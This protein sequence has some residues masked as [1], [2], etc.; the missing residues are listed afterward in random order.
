[1]STRSS[2]SSRY[3]HSTP[4]TGCCRGVALTPTGCC[5]LDR[6]LGLVP[7]SHRHLE[8]PQP[9]H[10]RPHAVRHSPRRGLLLRDTDVHN[11][12]ALSDLELAYRPAHLP[13]RQTTQ[14]MERLPNRRPISHPDNNCMGVVARC[15]EWHR[16]I[17]WLDSCL[18]WAVPPAVVVRPSLQTPNNTLTKAQ[19]S[20]IPVYPR[21][22]PEQHTP[23]H[24]SSHSLPL[25]RRYPGFAQRN[26]GHCDRD[27][28]QHTFVGRLGH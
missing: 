24:C 28:V 5:Y 6:P 16:R 2:S 26:M 4:H 19:D 13:A 21:T 12:A 8:L 1:M 3:A 7:H 9:C 22:P 15:G 18:G 27:K 14:A 17:Y 23:A 25:D 20:C 10:R 11:N